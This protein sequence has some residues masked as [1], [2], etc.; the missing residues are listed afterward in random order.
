MNKVSCIRLPRLEKREKPPVSFL[1]FLLT[2]KVK[3]KSSDVCVCVCV[4]VCVYG[5][6][7]GYVRKAKENNIRGAIF[8][9]LVRKLIYMIYIFTFPS[10]FT[11]Y[12]YI[13]IFVHT[14]TVSLS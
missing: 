13:Y 10:N 7:G 9:Y 12:T 1:F 11:L 3:G 4:C 8:C 5:T 2:V 14:I 6:V